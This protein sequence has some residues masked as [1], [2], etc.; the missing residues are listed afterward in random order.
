MKAYRYIHFVAVTFLFMFLIAPNAASA[1]YVVN[2]TDPACTINSTPPCFTT[3]QSAI[4]SWASLTTVGTTIQ[5]DAGTYHEAVVLTPGISL[6]GSETAKTILTSGGTSTSGALIATSSGSASISNFTFTNATLGI[7][8]TNNGTVDI[9]NNVFDMGQ[10]GTAIQIQQS[11]T[12]TRI[13]DNTFFNNSSAINSNADIPIT[14]NIFSNNTVALTNSSL[15]PTFTQLTY[16][17]F[18]A[19]STI[20]SNGQQPDTVTN[21]LFDPLFADSASGDFH[22][23]A[24]SPCRNVGNPAGQFT[25]PSYYPPDPAT[26]TVKSDMGAYGGQGTDSIP[27]QVSGV[28]ATTPSDTSISLNWNANSSYLIGGYRVYYGTA[29]GKYTGTGAAEGSSPVSVPTGTAATT[30][31]LTGL[32]ISAVTPSIPTLNSTAPLNESLVLSW[33]AAAGATGYKVYYGTTSPPSTAINVGNVTSY[34][35]SGLTNDQRYFVAVSAYA[36]ALLYLA[37]TARDIS[38]GPFDPGVNHESAYSTEVTAGSGNL[39]ESAPS[40]ILLDF[41]EA[42]V[43]YPN[44][45]NTHQGCFIATAAFGYYSAPQVQALREF[46]DHYLVTNSLGNAF[47]EWYYR[48]SPAAAGFLNAHP[49]YKPVVRAALMPAVGISLFL[50][51]TSVAM[52]IVLMILASCGIAYLLYRRRLSVSGGSR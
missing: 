33:T 24:T 29:S 12:S 51:Q 9:N 44:L 32:T 10:T 14:S 4:N 5:V 17:D 50:T 45:P 31:T 21:I 26:Q 18:F 22:L 15:V 41:P 28:T 52:K 39:M 47:V 37:V 16:N 43:A 3:I 13:F 42:L 35:L 19:N 30:F 1:N 8:V 34:K 23:T 36:K 2:N 38:T 7:L 6:H 20:A 25:N 11:T 48:V 46:R 27:F 40:N 49:G